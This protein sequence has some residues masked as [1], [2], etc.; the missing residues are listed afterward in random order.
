[1]GRCSLLAIFVG[2]ILAAAAGMTALVRPEMSASAEAI[3]DSAPTPVPA[4]ACAWQWAYRPLGAEMARSI[5]RD[6]ARVGI[7]RATVAGT[8]LGESCL[9]AGSGEM[10]YFAP[11]ETDLT[12]EVPA[13]DLNNDAVLSRRTAKVL[14]VLLEYSPDLT[15]GPAPGQITLVF[16]AGDVSTRLEFSDEQA[17]RA[18]DQGLEGAALLEALGPEH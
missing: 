8:V 10:L 3:P 6:L 7:R 11:M 17:A 2:L 14:G 16:S 15:P 9:D 18:L 5:E 13:G 4:D 1:M 12:V